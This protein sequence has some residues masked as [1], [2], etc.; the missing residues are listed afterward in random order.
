MFDFATFLKSQSMCKL[1]FAKY[2]YLYIY[3]YIFE[4]IDTSTCPYYIYIYTFKFFGKS[5][6]HNAFDQG[7]FFRP[8]K[9]ARCRHPLLS[10]TFWHWRSRAN[11]PQEESQVWSSSLVTTVNHWP[12]TII[13]QCKTTMI[14]QKMTS[15]NLLRSYLKWQFIN[16]VSFSWKLVIFDRYVSS[17][18][19]IN[20][21]KM[22]FIGNAMTC[23]W[24]TI[25]HGLWIRGGDHSKWQFHA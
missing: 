6:E 3:I 8:P 23:G 17:L 18:E 2:L 9:W 7:Y 4:Y 12:L 5:V 11:R 16:I 1:Y 15:G 13:K 21:R 20:H 14:Q 24:F 19:S 25:D 22:H 10:S